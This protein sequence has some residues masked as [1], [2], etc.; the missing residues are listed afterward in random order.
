MPY[1]PVNYVAGVQYDE[2]GQP[3]W[4]YEDGGRYF[5]SPLAA[6]SMRHE[7]KAV[8]WARSQ[9]VHDNPDGTLT[10]NATP[11]PSLFKE[12]G[13]WDADSGDMNQGVNWTNIASMGVGGLIAAPFVA[14]AVG[15]GAAGGGAGAAGGGAGTSA[16]T[17]GGLGLASGGALPL[18]TGLTAAQMTTPAFGSLLGATGA[19]G[20]GV[21]VAAA[22]TAATPSVLQRL[23]GLVPDS[24]GDVAKLAT[25]AAA[26]IP[27][28]TGAGNSNAFGNAEIEDEVKRALA[29]QRGRVEQAQ[30]VYDALVN[31]AYGMTP[32][33]YRGAQPAGYP[34]TAQHAPAGPYAYQGPRFR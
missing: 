10:N 17:A 24:I 21:P 16:S 33:R 18:G 27:Q 2:R 15:G 32:T 7:P 31:M 3:F 25:G 29:L 4:W 5:I 14:G 22:T 6:S 9:G 11:G 12:R 1:R 28:F 19:A 30:P 8:A 20:A 23:K 26:L 13:A 34:E